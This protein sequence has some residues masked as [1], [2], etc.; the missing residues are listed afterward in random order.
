MSSFMLRPEEEDS[1][2]REGGS[3]GAPPGRPG[4]ERRLTTSEPSFSGSWGVAWRWASRSCSSR[5][6]CSELLKREAVL[7]VRFSGRSAVEV[8]AVVVC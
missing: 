2:A 1:G 4:W 8:D 5:G 7:V 6:I 3:E